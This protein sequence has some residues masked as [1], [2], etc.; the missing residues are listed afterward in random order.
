[1][2]EDTRNIAGWPLLVAVLDEQDTPPVFTLAPPTT[3][4]SPSLQTGDLILR[5]HAEDG[6]RGKPR[7]I[8]YGLL[9]ENNPFVAFFDMSEETGKNNK[10][11]KFCR[12]VYK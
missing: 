7:D 5:V 2:E 8:R 1:M 10:D 3:I 6:D 12:H 9:A 11:R 4:L